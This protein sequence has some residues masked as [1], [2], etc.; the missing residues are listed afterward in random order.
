MILKNKIDKF[1]G[2]CGLSERMRARVVLIFEILESVSTGLDNRK[3][4]EFNKLLEL[5]LES[6][7][8][9]HI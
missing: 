8:L 5:V 4:I 2:Q 1:A 9:I 6:L 7:S 3:N